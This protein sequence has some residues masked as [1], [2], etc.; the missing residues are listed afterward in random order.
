MYLQL[1]HSPCVGP[2]VNPLLVDMNLL[3]WAPGKQ[4]ELAAILQGESGDPALVTQFVS[5][6]VISRCNFYERSSDASPEIA[7]QLPSIVLDRIQTCINVA[8]D[9]WNTSVRTKITA[10]EM[11][12]ETEEHLG[13]GPGCLNRMHLR[14]YS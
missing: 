2:I 7:L 5:V 10:E 14:K 11:F 4:G 8:F 13:T 1:S 12:F 3:T 9:T 6:A